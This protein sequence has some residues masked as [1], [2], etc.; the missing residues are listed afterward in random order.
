MYIL[1]KLY[2]SLRPEKRGEADELSI[3]PVSK[4]IDL[5]SPMRNQKFSLGIRHKI[6]GVVLLN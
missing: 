1:T 6:V 5:F 3:A 4:K 2:M